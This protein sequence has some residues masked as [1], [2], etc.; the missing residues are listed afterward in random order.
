MKKNLIC[1]LLAGV[2]LTP[3]FAAQTPDWENPEVFGVNNEKTRAVSLPYADKA[4]A[5]TDNYELS[6]YYLSLSGDWKFFGRRS[7]MAYRPHFM[8]PATTTVRGAR[9]LCLAI[10]N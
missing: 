5:M 6:P 9:C 10:G 2:M 1:V 3:A 4:G 7:P 8:K